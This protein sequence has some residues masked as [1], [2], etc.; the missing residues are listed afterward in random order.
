MCVQYQ[1]SCAP[2]LARKCEIEHWCACGADGRA[3]G[4][5]ITKF[6]WMGRLPHFISYGAPSTRASKI[7]RENAFEHK[8]KKPG[9][10]ANRPS[11]NWA[12]INNPQY[13]VA[14]RDDVRVRT[15]LG[16][17][18][19]IRTRVVFLLANVWV[20]TSWARRNLKK[21]CVILEKLECCNLRSEP[22]TWNKYSSVQIRLHGS[23]L[24]G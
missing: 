12:L 13:K 14:V 24:A 8:K 16:L 19:E 15:S 5:V 2:K 23:S 6:S 18:G 4:H 10:S 20:R 21:S 11:N 17:L 3:Y 7:I 1:F 22:Q 9:L